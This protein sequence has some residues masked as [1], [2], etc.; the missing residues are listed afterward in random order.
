[1]APPDRIATAPAGRPQSLG[2]VSVSVG[3]VIGGGSG[4][5]E[6]MDVVGGSGVAVP[7]D[8]VVTVMVVVLF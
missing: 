5:V 2:V 3:S 7:D 6:G 4:V 1:M 8:V